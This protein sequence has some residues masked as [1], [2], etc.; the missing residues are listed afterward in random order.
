[1]TM[2][3]VSYL[4]G[5]EGDEY[6][7][8]AEDHRL[9]GSA[10]WTPDNTRS[11]LG[12]RSGVVP[13]PGDPGGVTVVAGGVN[14]NQ[15]S[16]VIQGAETVGQGSYV[17]TS[18]AVEFRAIT[19]ASATEFRRGIVI[20]HVYDQ[21]I[22][23][24]EDDWDIEVLYG[25]PA[26]TAAQAQ[27]PTVPLNCLLMKAFAVSNT[28]VITLSGSAAYT[29]PR[30]AILP[31]PD[32]SAREGLTANQRWAG[33]QVLELDTGRLLWHDGTRWR[34]DGD[35]VRVNSAAE[36]D[37]LTAYE[38]LRAFVA[39][40]GD[41]V[42]AG[43]AWVLLNRWTNTINNP[44][45]NFSVTAT[46]GGTNLTGA[47]ATVRVPTG[48]TLE[49]E[50]SVPALTLGAGTTAW[51]RLIIA[52]VAADAELNDRPGF[53]GG[54]LS[55]EYLNVT[56]VPVDVSYSIDAYVGA[57]SGTSFVIQASGGAPVR[58]RH[59]IV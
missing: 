37:A 35:Y 9:N 45:Y 26:A 41:Y 8:P 27:Y 53:V 30:N 59:K 33:M 15:F 48:R 51:H 11:V 46:A 28:G 32:Q 21:L 14:I 7:L 54:R 56:G 25:P 40:S 57:G 43:T 42:Y 18:D 49:V 23:D 2:R 39:G 34:Y 38:G 13:G 5:V 6:L 10:L 17:V 24:T 22:N 1:M 16:A 20:A 12:V 31:L 50:W 47:T 29:V 44:S 36:R 55:G 58:L 4:Q 19:A 3:K 52:G